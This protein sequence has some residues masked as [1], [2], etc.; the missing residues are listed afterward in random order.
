[1][2]PIGLTID[3]MKNQPRRRVGLPERQ[4]DVGYPPP[5]AQTPKIRRRDNNALFR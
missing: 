2:I 4:P 5:E 1:M 3:R